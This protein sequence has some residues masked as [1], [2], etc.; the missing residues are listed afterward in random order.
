MNSYTYQRQVSQV[1]FMQMILFQYV[2]YIITAFCCSAKARGA[3][4]YY[5]FQTVAVC[6]QQQQQQQ[7][8][9]GT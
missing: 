5:L 6:I 8:E 1:P 4:L 2:T 3:P 7:Q 9:L